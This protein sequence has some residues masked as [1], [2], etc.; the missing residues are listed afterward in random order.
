MQF[1]PNLKKKKKTFILLIFYVL[2]IAEMKN[3]LL[4]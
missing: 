4:I 2:E 1:Q 3:I